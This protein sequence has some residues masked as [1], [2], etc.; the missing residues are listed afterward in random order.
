MG[1]VWFRFSV[2]FEAYQGKLYPRRMHESE[3]N[4]VY[5]ATTGFT[6]I[7]SIETLEFI[8]THVHAGRVNKK[9]KRL[10]YGQALQSPPYHAD[11]WSTYN[12]LKL[13]PVNEKLIKD[14]EKEIAL[15][16][17]FPKQ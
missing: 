7:A 16:E 10:R 11:F 15:Q 9:A 4:E 14:L 6:S 2:E 3:L 8:T 12:I 5:N 17:Q 13:T 1:R